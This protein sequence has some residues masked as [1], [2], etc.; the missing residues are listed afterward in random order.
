MY[1]PAFSVVSFFIISPFFA[2]LRV[3]FTDWNAFSH[4]LNYI[5]FEQYNRMFNDPDTW[6]V[7]KNTLLYGV[8]STLFQNLVGL[9]YA[10]LLNQSIRFKAATRTIIYLPVIISPL[11]MGYIWYFFFAYQ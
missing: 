5:G 3:S 10:L 9:G 6:I 1:L 8:G 4:T 11:I 2:G 7:V